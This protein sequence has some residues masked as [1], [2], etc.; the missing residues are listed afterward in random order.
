[1]KVSE[2]TDLVKKNESKHLK[3]LA[4]GLKASYK[5]TDQFQDWIMAELESIGM[6]TST[7]HVSPE[8]LK[9]Q[10]SGQKTLKENPS[11]FNQAK[12]VVGI[13]KGKKEI[14]DK[15][16]LLFAHPDKIPETFKWAENHPEMVEKDGK[17]YGP[18]IADD[19]AGITAMISAIEV[20]HEAG[21]RAEGDILM[22]AMLGKQMGIFG[23]YGLVTKYGPVGSSVYLHP[24][25][26]GRGLVDV[27]MA[28]MGALEYII[29][30][31]GKGPGPGAD[32]THALYSNRFI[33]AVDLGY[34]VIEGLRNWTN[35]MDKKHPHE[36][37]NAYVGHSVGMGIG[38]FIAGQSNK[39]KETALDCRIEG[40]FVFQPEVKLDEFKAGVIAEFD[41]IVK[42]DPWLAEGNATLTFGDQIDQGAQSDENHPLLKTAAATL[43]EIT[44]KDTIMYYAHTTSDLRYP[45]LYWKGQ[46]LGFGPIAGNMGT[47]N[48][49]VDKKEYLDSIV[50][51]VKIMDDVA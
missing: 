15:G 12:N 18:G 7:F 13:I 27:K 41:K 38:K 9:N 31:K 6:E 50:A 49:W 25:E 46:A 33:N 24:A 4:E 17:L 40:V 19:V 11:N 35:E 22:S 28:S 2:I 34:K 32:H 48:E 1:M 20:F 42:S 36:K 29:E 30:I 23:T 5:P 44:G 39:S 8:E 16:L 47:E 3:R 26:T 51:C 43:K 45:L 14:S 21:L 10:P 37:L